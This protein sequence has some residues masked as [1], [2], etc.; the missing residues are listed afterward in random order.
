MKR[1][2]ITLS[3]STRFMKEFKEVERAL[4]VDGKIPL[5]PAVYGKAEG[6]EY[7]QELSKEL[8][9]LHLDKIRM[10]EGIFV[11]DPDGVMGGRTH[12]EIEYAK[13]N[14]KSVRYYSK[15]YKS[16]IKP[17]LD[18]LRKNLKEIS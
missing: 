15:E 17:L 4:T 6:F 3:G 1:E 13:E 5:P 9:E 2:V 14:G 18:R 11:V 8:W 12:L 16:Y 10:S 7:S